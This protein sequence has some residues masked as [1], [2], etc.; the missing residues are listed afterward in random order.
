MSGRNPTRRVVL[1]LL[2]QSGGSLTL[3]LNDPGHSGLRRRLQE[4]VE[5]GQVELALRS[6]A[7]VT[8]ALPKNAERRPERF[9]PSD[10]NV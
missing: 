2:Q 9:Q 5:Q 6:T 3:P 8:Y 7:S 4:L 10:A 1:T